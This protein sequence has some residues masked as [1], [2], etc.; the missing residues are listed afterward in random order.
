[1]QFL[2]TG[3][4]EAE[5]AAAIRANVAAAIS[6]DVGSGDVSA[7]LI[8][9]NSTANARVITREAGVIAG[10]PWVAEV[11]RQVDARIAFEPSTE[12]GE[13]VDAGALLYRLTGPAASLLTAERPALNFLQLLSGTATLTAEY[14]ALIAHTRTRLLD[15]RKTIPGLRLAQKYAV[16]C[17]GGENHRI[18]LYDQFLIK[19]NHIAAA[20]SI[21]AAVA[22]ARSLHPELKVEVEVENLDELQAAM[23]AGADIVMVDDFSLEDTDKAAQMARGRVLLESSGGINRETIVKVAEA[24]VDYISVGELTKTVRPLDLSMRFESN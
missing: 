20:G 13:R 16:R 11:C 17:G 24:G 2:P 10:L 22:R 19:E 12:D 5:L 21:A 15:T 7:A 4:T 1:M 8:D 14:A 6:E 23:N 3:V 9:P 18:G